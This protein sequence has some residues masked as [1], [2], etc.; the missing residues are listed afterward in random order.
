[1]TTM[2]MDPAEE[3]FGERKREIERTQVAADEANSYD[4]GDYNVDRRCQLRKTSSAS[5]EIVLEK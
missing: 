3:E 5:E 2:I 4:I 1:M